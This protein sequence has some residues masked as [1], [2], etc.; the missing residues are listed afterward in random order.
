M[1]VTVVSTEDMAMD[2]DILKD[3]VVLTVPDGMSLCVLVMANRTG[4]DVSWTGKLA[5][6]VRV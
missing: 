6:L 4:I 1:D 2:I 3:C 5:E